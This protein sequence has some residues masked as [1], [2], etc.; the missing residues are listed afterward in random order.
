M[1][2]IRRCGGHTEPL[3]LKVIT[4]RD[5]KYTHPLRNPQRCNTLK[6]L[7]Y[8]IK[9]SPSWEV[10]QFSANQGIPRILWNPNVHY[11]FHKCPPPVPVLRQLYPSISPHPTS[12]RSILIL[13]SHLQLDLPSGLVFLRFPHQNPAYVSPIP[14]RATCPAHRILVDLVTQTIL[15]EEYGSLSLSLCNLKLHP[16]NAKSTESVP[17]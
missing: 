3:E 6:S 8:S 5:Y 13:S 4:N 2:F 15:C 17:K 16:T 1:W 14:I 7:T 12:W 9:Q 10:N 11:R